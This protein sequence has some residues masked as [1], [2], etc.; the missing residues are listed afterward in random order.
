[1]PTDLPESSL[2][3]DQ[4]YRSAVQ[5]LIAAQWVEVWEIV[6]HVLAS[7]DPEHVREVRVAS[8]HLWATMDA[9]IGCFSPRS[10]R[11]L[12]PITKRIAAATGDIR[13]CDVQI[14]ALR[15][16][17]KNHSDPSDRISG[18][19]GLKLDP[20]ASLAANAVLSCLRPCL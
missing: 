16:F 11:P 4:D 9:G 8:R 15:A 1:M 18:R 3:P 6:P 19:R 2:N 7:D 10:Y 13:D 12:H 20:D 5:R 14:D 17:R